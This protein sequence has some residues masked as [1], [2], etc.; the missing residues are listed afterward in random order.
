MRPIHLSLNCSLDDEERVTTIGKAVSLLP[1]DPRMGRIL[2][3]GCIFGC[4]PSVLA[5]AAA[6]GYKDPFLMPMNDQQRAAG[7]A[8]KI[9]LSQ[10][11]PSD[12]IALLRA[13]EGLSTQKAHHFCDDNFLS[14]SVM[15]YLKDL[16][17]QLIQTLRE[18]GV[19]STQAYAQRNNGNMPLIMSIISIGLYPD[20]GVRYE[21]KAPFLLEKGRKAKIHPSSV[22][23][24]L[25]QFKGPCTTGMDLVGFQ[26]LVS[27]PTAVP[28]GIGLMMLNTTVMSVF[29][30][31]LT[32]G[33]I[34]E[35]DDNDEDSS[36]ES[37]HNR[38][39]PKRNNGN[40]VLEIDGWIK[41]K[42]SSS[43]LALIKKCRS[44]VSEAMEAFLCNPD[45]PLPQHLAKG[46][47]AIAQALKL[48][49]PSVSIAQDRNP[50]RSDRSRDHQ[51]GRSESNSGG[52]SG[53]GGRGRGRGRD[54][55]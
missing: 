10:G 18:S 23:S 4:A 48:E 50:V 54:Y 6:M 8:A 46:A 45:T 13:F 40:V 37:G 25:P 7:N 3:L 21:G 28:G 34:K 49:H 44:T 17:Q 30:L 55:R 43:A 12:Q 24:K 33:I 35:M 51:Y 26:N 42:I 47:D 2:L 11:N 53:G 1:L 41:L 36:D 5:T 38:G 16:V 15:N 22:N 29:S 27:S 20:M 19:N 32:C 31:L 9:R 39:S 14:V 52:G